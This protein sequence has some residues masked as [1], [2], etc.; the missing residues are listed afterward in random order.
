MTHLRDRIAGLSPE[1]RA[2]LE[3]RLQAARPA[4][5]ERIPRRRRDDAP[6]PL[7]F[8]QQRLWF[9]EQLE[10][11]GS[12]YNLS[13]A[14]RLDGPLWAAELEQALTEIVRRHEALRTR[15]ATV[16]GR[17]AQVIAGD[18]ALELAVVELTGTPAAGRDDEVARLATLEAHRPFD[19]ARGPLLRATLFR[20]GEAAHV[21]LLAM[22]HIVSDG[23]SLGVLQRELT[24]LYEA[25]CA[26][27]PSPLPE[28]PLQ[29]A[30]FAVWQRHQ[31]TGEPLARLVAYWRGQL[32]GAP[33][34]LELPMDRPRPP[35]QAYRGATYTFPIAASRVEG[36]RAVVR[37]ADATL[38]MGV[39][40]VFAI[41]LQRYARTPDVVIG[42]PIANRTR[43]E[44]EGLVGF[45]VN[46]L[47]LRVDLA[48]GPTFAEALARVR[49]MTLAAFAH[50]DLP[51]DK[52]V[53][54]LAPERSAGHN[55]VFQVM[56]VLQNLEGTGPAPVADAP[57]FTAGTSKFDLTLNAA[58]ASDGSLAAALEYDTRLFD[59]PT[60][61]AM[62]DNLGSLLAAVVT[63]ADRPLATLAWLGDAERARHDARADQVVPAG[64]VHELCE[65]QARIRP[66]APAIRFLGDNL[67][68][69]ALNARANQLARALRDRGVG[70][71]VRVGLCLER[72]FELVICVLGVLKAG[73]AYV[74]LDP[75]HP[76]DRLAYTLD[77]AGVA[78]V[79]AQDALGDRLAGHGGAVVT[80]EALWPALDR[81]DPGDLPPLAT[82]DNA[83]YVIYTS[84]STGR[85]K[86][87]TL[88]HRGVWN[89][90]RAEQHGF[91][92]P[93]GARIQQLAPWSFDVSM[94]EL[95]LA[96]GAGGTLCLA[97]AAA[98]LPGP[99][100]VDLLR[101]E[102]IDVVVLSPSALAMLPEAPLPRLGTVIVGGEVCSLELVRRWAPGRQMFNVY[103][104]TEASIWALYHTCSPELTATPPIGGPLPGVTAHVLDDQLAPVPTGVPGEL[105]LGGACVGRGYHRRPGLTAERFVPDPFAAVPGARM[106]R[107][108][109][110]VRRLPG[111]E[112][113]FVARADAMVKIRGYRIEL[114]EIEAALASHPGVLAAVAAA[115]RDGFGD[116]RLAAYFVPQP[117]AALDVA[118][119]RGHLKT[120]LPDYMV[121]AAFVPLDAL[122]LTANGKLDRRALPAPSWDLRAELGGDRVAP[123]TPIEAGVAQ[124]WRDLLEI[125]EVGVF[126][127]FFMLGG[128]SLLVTRVASR[129]ASAFGVELPLRR[130]FELPTV[131]QLADAIERAKRG[132]DGAREPVLAPLGREAYR[133]VIGDPGDP[134]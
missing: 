120:V 36:L 28:L 17:A 97:P 39:V 81:H 33:P 96:L 99:G 38:F 85:P 90:A 11:G 69:G 64:C 65:A 121:P 52:L 24:A 42:T 107:T 127:D 79:I 53:E 45:F 123:R 16:D 56:V 68:Y 57:R 63:G 73:G 86:G 9:L 134:P 110:L 87:A 76:P 132:D 94:F 109:D 43:V 37:R 25:F 7:S 6:I 102:Q 41:L 113:H 88:T 131:A 8:A 117:G 14:I 104:P 108:G 61:A 106:Y 112:L 27:R 122:P 31:L 66:D 83:I 75:A 5:A 95:L 100:F 15:F 70:P 23:W 130:V 126:D 40:A 93:P 103:G 3:R 105:Y 46:T 55:P 91:A 26:G 30:D 129:V 125:P 77:D 71:E 2:L 101:D 116:L 67:S 34:L 22:H 18:A 82:A 19:L 59:G 74:P 51:F 47:V 114:G 80:V 119:L 84:G 89:A 4:V 44:L 35:V 98:L 20:L 49:E 133:T 111:G 124:I 50:Q 62:A 12:F 54:E 32:A 78:L 128:H 48:G 115:R 60:I 13:F 92:L 29:Y 10:P 118:E 21:L 58:E 72:S 1:K